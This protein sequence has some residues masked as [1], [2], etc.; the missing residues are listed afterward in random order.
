MSPFPFRDVICIRTRYVWVSFTGGWLPNR[1]P[2]VAKI[3]V[4]VG[5]RIHRVRVQLRE[6]II[7]G[8]LFSS[9]PQLQIPRSEDRS[10]QRHSSIAPSSPF[11]CKLF[12]QCIHIH[13]PYADL[14]H[15]GH[16]SGNIRTQPITRER[17]LPISYLQRTVHYQTTHKLHVRY[18]PFPDLFADQQRFSSRVCVGGNVCSHGE[19]TS[20]CLLRENLNGWFF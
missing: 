17:P 7:G 10:H 5:W 3:K 11:F 14:L 6:A 4:T 19:R 9:E 13:L 15:V 16:V 18:P 2:P 12:S 20:W 1:I 8:L